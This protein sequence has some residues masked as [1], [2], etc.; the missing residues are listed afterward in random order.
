MIDSTTSAVVSKGDESQNQYLI[1]DKQLLFEVSLSP[2][3]KS[4]KILTEK[5]TATASEDDEQH[6]L[7]LANT[8][9]SLSC[10]DEKEL[11]T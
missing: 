7:E 5:S 3:D 11:F 1:G 10:I 9:S 2:H 8:E 4:F 6:N